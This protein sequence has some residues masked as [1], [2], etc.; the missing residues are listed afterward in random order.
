MS[1]YGLH[2]LKLGGRLHIRIV[3]KEVVD[4]RVDELA[5]LSGLG[6]VGRLLINSDD[7]V[8]SPAYLGFSQAVS[9]HSFK[10]GH[11]SLESAKN[12]VFL[13]GDIGISA[14]DDL[15]KFPETETTVEVW[16]VSLGGDVIKTLAHY[17]L[18]NALNQIHHKTSGSGIESLVPCLAFPNHLNGR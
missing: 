16:R 1:Q 13:Q 6:A 11:E 15:A 14:F 4:Q 7:L 12:V 9:L 8:L 3:T 5:V 2:Q 18:N 17:G 10:F